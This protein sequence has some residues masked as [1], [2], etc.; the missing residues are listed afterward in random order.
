[1]IINRVPKRAFSGGIYFLCFLLFYSCGRSSE[2]GMI[3]A[4]LS[5]SEMNWISEESENVTL[6]N[7]PYTLFI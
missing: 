7:N 4:A 1:M 6:Y 3:A 5:D 2:E